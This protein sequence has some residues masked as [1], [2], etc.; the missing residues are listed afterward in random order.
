MLTYDS[1]LSQYTL[2]KCRSDQGI[3]SYQAKS[4]HIAWQTTTK[5]LKKET[6]I[7]WSLETHFQGI[8]EVHLEEDQQCKAQNWP[9]THF[10]GAM[11]TTAK[12]ETSR[13]E[14][15]IWPL[16]DTYWNGKG[17]F[18]FSGKGA[19][20]G[21]PYASWSD[22]FDEKQSVAMSAALGEGALN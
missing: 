2:G 14:T 20:R 17:S 3:S 22:K 9:K 8:H 10:Q 12:L 21:M 4:K 16:D 7:V 13:Q 18:V 6:N 5:G 1:Q 11:P 15:T 19:L